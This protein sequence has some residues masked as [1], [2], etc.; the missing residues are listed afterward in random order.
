MTYTSDL[1]LNRLVDLERT[2]FEVTDVKVK[3]KEISPPYFQLNTSSHT[4]H[5]GKCACQLRLHADLEPVKRAL[6]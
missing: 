6:D 4:N 3:I 2:N 1:I 5:E